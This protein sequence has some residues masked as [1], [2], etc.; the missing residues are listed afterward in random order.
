MRRLGSSSTKPSSKTELPGSLVQRPRERLPTSGRSVRLAAIDLRAI[1]VRAF[2]AERFGDGTVAQNTAT[3]LIARPVIA[4]TVC[5]AES[6]SAAPALPAADAI[7]ATE[8]RAFAVGGALLRGIRGRTAAAAQKQQ[9]QDHGP[10]LAILDF[11]EA[12]IGLCNVPVRSMR[13]R[14]SLQTPGLLQAQSPVAPHIPL[15]GRPLI[16]Q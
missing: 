1:E 5:A 16:W 13:Q 9:H 6:Q 2:L 8:T 3:P 10:H 15:R 12:A 11:A 14:S 7:I 4:G